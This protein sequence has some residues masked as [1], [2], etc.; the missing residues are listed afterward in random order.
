M[1]KEFAPAAPAGPAPLDQVKHS[2]DS[3]LQYVSIQVDGKTF[4]GWYRLLED[5]RME[6]LALA[7]VHCERR[8]ENTAIEQAR[9]MLADFIAS[10]ANAAV[11]A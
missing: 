5:G 7:N 1:T 4:G 9:G 6:L 3:D 2:V 10:H 8:P 11:K